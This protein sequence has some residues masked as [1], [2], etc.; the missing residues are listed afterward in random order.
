MDSGINGI[1]GVFKIQNKVDA[2]QYAINTT[3]KWRCGEGSQVDY[4]EAK[5]LFD[6]FCENADFPKDPATAVMDGMMP[7]LEKFLNQ[8]GQKQLTESPALG[9]WKKFDGSAKTVPLAV[10]Y[11]DN[12]F[13]DHEIRLASYAE[14]S[15]L[16]LNTRNEI[17][18]VTHYLEFSIMSLI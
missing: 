13:H 3:T 2:L 4:E 6:F 8:D 1:V 17:D 10:V 16:D 15:W 14:G 12:A 11:T 5:K 9:A 7:M 18:D